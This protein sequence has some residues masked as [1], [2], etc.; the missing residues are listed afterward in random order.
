MADKATLRWRLIESTQRTSAE[1][2][3]RHEV[4]M[5][6]TVLTNMHTLIHRMQE[7]QS[8]DMSVTMDDWDQMCA[9]LAYSAEI[10]RSMKQAQMWPWCFDSNHNVVMWLK[11]HTKGKCLPS[12][13][14]N[15][16][17]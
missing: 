13:T 8:Y 5:S 9:N 12:F 16:L 6:Q 17:D 1:Y 4:F 14:N 2:Y 7:L 15:A 3:D 10:L 11:A